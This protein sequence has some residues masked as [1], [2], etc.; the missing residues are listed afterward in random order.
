MTPVTRSE[1]VKAGAGVP[2]A[3]STLAKTG[4]AATPAGRFDFVVA[5][6]GHNSQLCAAYLAKAGYKIVVLEG[7]SG[8]TK[9]G[10]KDDGLK[11]GNKSVK[12]GH[13]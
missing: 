13:N 5:G 10:C 2:L 8:R 12:R 1:F 3:L 9:Q 6:A 7:Q 4:R 11:C